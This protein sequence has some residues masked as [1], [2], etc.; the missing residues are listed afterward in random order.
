MWGKFNYREIVAP[1]R[2]VF[3][4]S[5]ADA[6]GIITG[7]PGKTDWPLEVLHT[8]TFVEHDG[9]TTLTMHGIPIKATEVERSTFQAG[10]DG[11]R[12]GFGGTLG[13]LAQYLATA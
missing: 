13:Q 12:Q 7:Y 8:L 10:H 11:M 4:L 5:F 2:L 3:I 9:K 6:H 1:E